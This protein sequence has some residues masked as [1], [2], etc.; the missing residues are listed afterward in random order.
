MFLNRRRLPRRRQISVRH[1]MIWL[2]SCT[3]LGQVSG[4]PALVPGWGL[5]FRRHNRF[6]LEVHHALRWLW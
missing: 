5:D 6:C 3:P 2:N 1:Q 4:I